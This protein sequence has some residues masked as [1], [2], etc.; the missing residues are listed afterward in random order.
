PRVLAVTQPVVVVGPHTAKSAECLRH[1]RRD[2]EGAR[3]WF[4]RV[5]RTKSQPGCERNRSR[6][7]ETKREKPSSRKP[8]HKKSATLGDSNSRRMWRL[9]G[10][11]W[12]QAWFELAYP[13]GI[14]QTIVSR[15]RSRG[16]A[17]C[18]CPLFPQ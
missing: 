12:A 17:P 18:L 1:D 5:G 9:T 3:R 10:V 6:S 4:D 15:S 7:H 13:G 8:R 16:L 14:D 11:V 2:R